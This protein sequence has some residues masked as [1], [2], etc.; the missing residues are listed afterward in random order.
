M[1]KGLLVNVE[2]IAEAVEELFTVVS[3]CAD[4]HIS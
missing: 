4:L 3:F 2:P 1:R